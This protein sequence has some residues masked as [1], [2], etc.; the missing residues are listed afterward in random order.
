MV[1]KSMM[2]KILKYPVV[3]LKAACQRGESETLL[4]GLTALF[5]LEKQE[6]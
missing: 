6:A 2:Q 4:E 3:E 1:T 5:N